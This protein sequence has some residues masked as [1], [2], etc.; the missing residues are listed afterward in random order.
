MDDGF[1]DDV[2]NEFGQFFPT[3]FRDFRCK[4]NALNV[5]DR[6]LCVPIADR[7]VMIHAPYV[8]LLKI[9]L[10]VLRVR[11]V[12]IGHRNI[13]LLF[14]NLFRGFDYV[15]G[16]GDLYVLYNLDILFLDYK[17][18]D[19]LQDDGVFLGTLNDLWICVRNF[20]FQYLK[21]KI[22]YVFR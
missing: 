21:Q 20:C 8:H 6:D 1:G 16:N 2:I 10:L 14:G 22:G 17:I 13:C 18:F 4:S 3:I 15:L 9:V 7:S 19:V 12:C 5:R 11:D